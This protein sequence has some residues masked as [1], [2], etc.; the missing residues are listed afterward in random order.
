AC[1]APCKIVMT[2][3]AQSATPSVISLQSPLP[4][5]RANGVHIQPTDAEP[6]FGFARVELRGGAAGASADGLRIEGAS[7]VQINGFIVRNF[8]RHGLVVDGATNTVV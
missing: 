2:G 7:N 6:G 3:I 8:S 4:P 5:I 1:A